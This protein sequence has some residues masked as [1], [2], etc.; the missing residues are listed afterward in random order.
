MVLADSLLQIESNDPNT[1]CL[2]DAQKNSWLSYG[3]LV[4][5]VFKLAE[6][7][8]S[9]RPR[10]AFCYCSRDIDSIVNYLAYL[11]AGQPLLLLDA[12]LPIEV[13]IKME[14]RYL[15]EL[16]LVPKS[17]KP[18]K[19]TGY[20]PTEIMGRCL[21]FARYHEF[22]LP[23]PHPDLA[24]LLTTSGSTGNP[25]LVRLSWSNLTANARSIT[26]ALKLGPRERAIT[27]LP[28]HYSFGLSVLNSHIWS[29]GSMVV[30]D[31]SPLDREFWKLFNQESCSSFAGVPFL[32]HLLRRIRFERLNLPSLRTMTQAGGNLN[33]EAVKWFHECLSKR[34]QR[35]LIMYGQTEATARMA[36][37]PP[38]DLPRKLGSVGLAIDGGS[39]SVQSQNGQVLPANKEGE[40]IYRGPN[41]M[42]GYAMNRGDMARGD[43]KNGLLATGDFGYLDDDGYLFITGRLKRFS[44]I[45]GFR[46]NLDD[47]E[48]FLADLGPTAVVGNDEGITIFCC[49]GH[50]SDFTQYSRDLASKL[51]IPT[52]VFTFRRVKTLP[53]TPSGK[54]DYKALGDNA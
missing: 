29:G 41:V 10:L 45:F 36:C 42:M 44:K 49:H 37:L 20:K 27:S 9:S 53:L 18:R 52:Q 4:S 13:Q 14:N 31:S 40:I 24:L 33:R 5:E 54:P 6:H 2:F 17:M 39:F 48:G 46:I 8:R 30:T 43:D 50:D 25:K 28:M 16:I 15:P 47:I 7:F 11:Q 26:M 3:Q 12:S 19:R 22:D 35:L 51:K 1:P 32:Y 38:W 34:G 21:A 23:S